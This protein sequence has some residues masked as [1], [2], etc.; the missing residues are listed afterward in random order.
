MAAKPEITLVVMT[1][2]Q[3]IITRYARDKIGATRLTHYGEA[4]REECPYTFSH[5]DVSRF[6]VIPPEA[7]KVEGMQG[8]GNR[9]G[10]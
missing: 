3:G 7:L 6:R 5:Q 8:L 4:E 9:I 10:G 1:P 2:A